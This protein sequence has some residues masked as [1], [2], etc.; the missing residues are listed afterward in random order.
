MVSMAVVV[1]LFAYLHAIVLLVTW[2]HVTKA[3]HPI[4]IGRTM[5]AGMFLA[6]A[7]IGSVLGKVRRNPYMGVRVPWTL[8]SDRVWDDTHRLAAWCFVCGGLLAF[9]I[10][11]V[12][13]S[14]AFS[15][16]V[17]IVAVAI[18]VIYSFVDYKRLERQGAL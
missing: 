8:A 1:G 12:G 3:A 11:V 9:V 18:P 13:L 16:A 17:M 2:Q 7:L 14:L 15:F 5:F 6:L 10:L 4:D